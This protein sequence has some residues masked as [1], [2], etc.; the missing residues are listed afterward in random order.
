MALRLAHSARSLFLTEFLAAFGLSIRYMS[1]P[2]R[3][4]LSA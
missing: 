4:S 1:S 2:G 3:R